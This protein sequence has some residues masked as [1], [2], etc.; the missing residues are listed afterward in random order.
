MVDSPLWLHQLSAIEKA[1]SLNEMALFFQVGTGKTRTTIEILRHN[2][3]KHKKILRTFVICPKSVMGNWKNE[4][5]KFSK[6]PA[7]HVF[8][9]EGTLDKRISLLAKCPENSIFIMNYES[10]AFDKF[11]KATL[12]NPPNILILDESHRVKGIQAKRTKNLIKLSQSMKAK[13]DLAHEPIYRYIL[14]GTPVLQNMMDLFSQFQILDCG[15]TLGSNYFAYRATYFYD[16]NAFMSK[17]KH[18]PNWQPKPNSEEKLK[19]LIAA[20]VV[21]AN[22]DECLDLPPLVKTELEVD[23]SPEQKRHYNEMKKEFITFCESGV[24]TAQLAI[25]KA[26]RMQQILSGYLQLESGDIV[27]I[28]ENP[29][30]AALEELLEDITPT[31]KVI[32]W[33]I[34]HYDYEMI[35][36]IC[37]KLGLKYSEVTGLVKDKQKELDMFE[38]DPECRVMIASPKAGGVGV[39]MIAASTMIYYSRS[40][41]LEDDIQS[42]ARNY[43]GG[44]EVH[45]KITRIDLVARGT[46]DELVLKALR[47]KKNL[48]DRILDLKDL[49]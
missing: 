23:L 47:E 37:K 2:Y 11:V 35:K 12:M 44:S 9:L 49:L 6:I 24:V 3:N 32:I 7:A 41:S 25:T 33:S 34:F 39:N 26:L 4:I 36:G 29:R 19:D 38:K 27:K 13:A 48:A 10:F 40:Y 17:Q 21:L 14:T 28:E 1:K 42:E 31:E 46:V 18:F 30:A 8:L 5:F 15:K 43:R 22:K 45:K 16:K 20:K